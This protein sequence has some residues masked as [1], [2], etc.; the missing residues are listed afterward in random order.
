MLSWPSGARASDGV[1]AEYWYAAVR[2]STGFASY[3][4]RAETL[5]THLEPLAQQAL[6]YYETLY[7]YRLQI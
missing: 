7:Q 3:R 6:P 1:W 5:P 2:A 4:P